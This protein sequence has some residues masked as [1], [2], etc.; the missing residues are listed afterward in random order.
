[1]NNKNAASSAHAEN[2]QITKHPSQ[3]LSPHCASHAAPEANDCSNLTD[4]TESPQ[5]A[6]TR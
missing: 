5:L 6:A 1:M 4:W 3:P 2:M